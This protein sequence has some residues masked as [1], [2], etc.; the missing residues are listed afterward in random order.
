MK[1][2]QALASDHERFLERSVWAMY[3]VLF[4]VLC[5]GGASLALLIG[6]LPDSPI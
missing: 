4:V 2:S 3:G 1:T 5:V 6:A